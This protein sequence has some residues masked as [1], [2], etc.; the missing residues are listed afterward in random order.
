MGLVKEKVTRATKGKVKE[1][2]KTAFPK[3]ER[4]PWWIMKLFCK[5]KNADVAVYMDGDKFCGF[6]HIY[7]TEKMAFVLYLAVNGEERGKG[8]GSQILDILKSA[9]VD[10]AI[11]L[12]IEPIDENAPNAE[13]RKSRLRFYNRNGFFDTGYL[14][15]DVGGMFTAMSNVKDFSPKEY[16]RLFKALSFNFWKAKVIKKDI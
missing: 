5:R 4:L 2:Y 3:E 11:V 9:Y 8:Y 12:N 15:E 7:E 10:K 13:Q 6:T 14:V 16:Q 1:L